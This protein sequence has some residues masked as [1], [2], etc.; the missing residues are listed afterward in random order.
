MSNLTDLISAAGGGGSL[1]VNIVLT[2]SQT[3]V[4]PVDGNICIH[5]VGGGS[6]G[7]GTSGYS[8]SSGAAGGYCK[9][10]SLAVTTSGSFTVVVGAAG[11]ATTGDSSPSGA[12][13][14]STVAGTGL[15][16]TLTANG[17]AAV[18]STS[19]RA[20]GGS[21]SNGDVNRTGGAGGQF[22]GGAVGIY[23]TGEQ[24]E[25]GTQVRNAGSVDSIG[26]ESLMGYGVICGGAGGIFI[27]QSS[28]S[29]SQPAPGNGQN[30]GFLSGGG[31]IRA[32]GSGAARTI[33]GGEAGV[34]GG[35][36]GAMN[37]QSNSYSRGGRGGDGIVIIQ[38]LPA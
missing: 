38:Y 28:S 30:G 11:L 5:V 31:A 37:T 35:G 10:N 7:R 18:S 2:K 36:G 8:M 21:A 15:S 17:G 26:P 24:S 32:E 29:P 13:G 9:K 4:P 6:G 25:T 16:S 20:A 27:Y 12:G 34:G 14:A 22:G 23:G 1:P 19:S 33:F 3:W